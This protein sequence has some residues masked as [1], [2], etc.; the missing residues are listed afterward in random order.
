MASSS[1]ERS[2]WPRYFHSRA[3]RKYFT[4][5]QPFAAML[6]SLPFVLLAD[7]TPQQRP[8]QAL[9]LSWA[10]TTAWPISNSYYTNCHSIS[11]LIISSIS[12]YIQLC[13]AAVYLTISCD[14]I[15]LT[16]YSRLDCFQN[17]G[18]MVPTGYHG[19]LGCQSRL[20]RCRWRNF[21]RASGNVVG[22]WSCSRLFSDP[23]PALAVPIGDPCFVL[24][25]KYGCFEWLYRRFDFQNMCIYWQSQ[26]FFCLDFVDRGALMSN[27]R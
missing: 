22:L 5:C 7:S 4:A 27:N 6:P 19:S 12:H 9:T 20:P 26:V 11:H 21:V 23:L 18:T 10:A 2:T 3:T 15:N 1:W 14:M 8:R 13:F 24:R 16:W 17:I 25:C